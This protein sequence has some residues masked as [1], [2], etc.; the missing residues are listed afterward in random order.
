MTVVPLVE[1]GLG[2]SSYVVDLDDGRALVVD[3]SVDLPAAA[4]AAEPRGLT[5]AVTAVLEGGAEDWAAA[6]GRHLES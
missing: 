3:V 1:E 4:A 6:T 2:N 5:V